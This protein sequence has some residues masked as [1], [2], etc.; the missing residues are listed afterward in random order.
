[1]SEALPVQSW[2]ERGVPDELVLLSPYPN[3]FNSSAQIEFELPQKVRS[4]V[5]LFDVTG[6]E[7]R[8][9]LNEMLP[10][11]YHS[12]QVDGT[13]LSTGVYF[14]RLTAGPKTLSEKIILI[15]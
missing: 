11:G 3:P 7:A 8:V 15:K 5:A 9:L 10:A 14:V 13:K 12:V 6:R 4:K 2:P 1:M